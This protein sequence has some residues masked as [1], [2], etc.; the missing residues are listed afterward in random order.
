M[1]IRNHQESVFSR[2]TMDLITR[3]TAC[4][5]DH[6]TGNWKCVLVILRR[7]EGWRRE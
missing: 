1:S 4:R 2:G 3:S 6:R 7:D 5:Y